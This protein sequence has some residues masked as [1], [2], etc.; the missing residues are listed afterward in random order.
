[1]GLTSLHPALLRQ[2]VADFCWAVQAQVFA[3]VLVEIDNA[4]DKA[5]VVPSGASAQ[6][7]EAVVEQIAVVKEAVKEPLRQRAAN[8][9]A[10]NRMAQVRAERAR[11]RV[12]SFS[13]TPLVEPLRAPAWSGVDTLLTAKKRG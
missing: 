9:L 2:R 3:E 5:L 10:E 8:Y 7:A 4:F 12:P 11:H 6:E 1:V 13:G